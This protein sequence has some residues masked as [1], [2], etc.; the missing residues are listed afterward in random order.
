MSRAVSYCRTDA[1]VAPVMMATLP[2]RRL[3]TPGRAERDA[4]LA[5]RSTSSQRNAHQ[6]RR[7]E[8][9][10][11]Q[12]LALENIHEVFGEH[13]LLLHAHTTNRLENAFETRRIPP[14]DVDA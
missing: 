2:R 13:R 8:S 6:A 7:V 4:G 3:S 9:S 10:L 11:Q 1:A 5:L 14:A 12:R